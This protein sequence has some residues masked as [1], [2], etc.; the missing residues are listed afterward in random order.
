MDSQSHV[1]LR[2]PARAVWQKA[3]VWATG[4]PAKAWVVLGFFLGAALLMAV[5]TAVTA[6]DAN[7]RL[8]VQ[9][10]FRSADLSVWVDGDLEYSGK[11]NGYSRRHSGRIP[12][13][14]QGSLSETLPVS[15][16]THQVRVRVASDDGSVQE[17]TISAGFSRNSQRTLAVNARHSDLELSW[18]GESSAVAEA[19]SESGWMGRYAGTLLL[20]IAG[21]IISALTGYAIKELPA[22]IR[23]RQNAAPKV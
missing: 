5:H 23:A 16:G 8:K 20:T 10:S 3:R 15:S 17:D 18:Q 21:S 12:D 11:L 2:T 19:S 7:L 13:S 9:H 14:P 4:V 6:K 22:H 1:D